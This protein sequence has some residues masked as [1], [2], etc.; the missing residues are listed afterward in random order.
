MHV[1]KSTLSSDKKLEFQAALLSGVNT[2]IDNDPLYQSWR[3]YAMLVHGSFPR[4]N[5]TKQSSVHATFSSNTPVSVQHEENN[6]YSSQSE[7]I[8]SAHTVAS[9]VFP[10]PKPTKNKRIANNEYFVMTLM[11][12]YR[13]KERLLT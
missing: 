6:L 11:K 9:Q 13:R 10:M 5:V 3:H 1:E 8:P 12:L 7:S 4:S 2:K